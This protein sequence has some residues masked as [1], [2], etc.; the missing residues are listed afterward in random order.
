MEADDDWQGMV[1]GSRFWVHLARHHGMTEADVSNMAIGLLL[2][3]H[4]ARHGYHYEGFQGGRSITPNVMARWQERLR[5]HD[6]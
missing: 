4:D 5:T 2:A 3:E 1:D 6:G